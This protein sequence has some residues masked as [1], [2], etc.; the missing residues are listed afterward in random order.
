[1]RCLVTGAAGFIGSHLVER[2]LA[3]GHAVVGI[4]GFVDNYD[5]AVK[6]SHLA[7]FA[8]HPQFDLAEDFIERLDLH[9][10]LHGVERV[11]H[12]AALPGVRSS[13]GSSFEDYSSHNVYATQR[14]LEAALHAG[15]GCARKAPL[16]LRGHEAGGGA[17][18]APV[19]PK[20]RAGDGQ[21]AVLYGL[22][23][24]PEAGHGHPTLPDCGAR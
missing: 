8:E 4:D 23:T 12:L 10:L 11:F 5:R 7:L 17:P 19:S 14:L 20:L 9:T 15:V 3:D 16:A 18:R 21:P 24:A 13:W 22:R 1:M 2:L 6:E